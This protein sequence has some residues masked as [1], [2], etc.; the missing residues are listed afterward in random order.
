MG[1]PILSPGKKLTG[2]KTDRYTGTVSLTGDRAQGDDS[3]HWAYSKCRNINPMI[4][5]NEQTNK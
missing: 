4:N 3:K 1:R 5:T 2:E